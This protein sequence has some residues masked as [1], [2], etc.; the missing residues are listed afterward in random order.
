[1]QGNCE[2]LAPP[3]PYLDPSHVPLRPLLPRQ[4]L[5]L[6]DDDLLIVYSSQV[7]LDGLYVRL[8][9]PRDTETG[10]FGSFISL[11]TNESQVWMTDVTLQG[12]GNGMRVCDECAL[13]VWLEGSAYAQGAATAHQ[14]FIALAVIFY[15]EVVERSC[16]INACTL[17]HVLVCLPGYWVLFCYISVVCIHGYTKLPCS[18]CE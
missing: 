14:H 9:T 17:L 3:S 12:N 15:A 11:G 13:S 1:M 5:L 18:R 16:L 2:G 8:T 6:A 10:L 7:W 4:C